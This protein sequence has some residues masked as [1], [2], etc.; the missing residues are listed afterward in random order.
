MESDEKKDGKIAEKQAQ[1]HPAGG[2]QAPSPQAASQLG[3]YSP[4]SDIPN[5]N[6]RDIS[7]VLD[8]YDDIF[9]DFDPRPYGQRELSEDFLKELS[10][11][12]TE[13]SRGNF[14][15]RF[16]IPSYERDPKVEGIIKKRLKAHFAREEKRVGHE[17]ASIRNRGLVYITF[18]VILLLG[19]TLTSVYFEN[20][21][22]TAVAGIFALPLGWFGVWTGVE[23]ILDIGPKA[24]G[25]LEAF[26][27]FVHCNY[28]FI[29]NDKE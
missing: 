27:K 29:S 11:R 16:F 2:Q 28:I 18:G 10:R 5:M 9:S 1:Q 21:L 26:A 12:Y 3:A 8:N 6:L 20:P 15:V 19:E 25:Q 14:E 22:L 7:I 17:M 23:R 4:S 13:D 24:R